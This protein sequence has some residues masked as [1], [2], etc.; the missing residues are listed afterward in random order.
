MK[1]NQL[2]KLS[3]KRRRTIMISNNIRTNRHVNYHE[4]KRMN[5]NT[6]EFKMTSGHFFFLL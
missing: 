3:I 2:I 6:L 1:V 5:K 4:M